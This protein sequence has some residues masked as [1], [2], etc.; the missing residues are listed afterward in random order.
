VKGVA[1]ALLAFEAITV[2]LAGLVA[3]T[4]TDVSST[5]AWSVC[6]GLFALCLAG[7]ATM[8][9][10]RTGWVLGS[11]AQVLAIATGFLVPAM[12]FLGAV[13]AA[14]WVLAYVLG[15]RMDAVTR[16]RAGSAGAGQG[17][18]QGAG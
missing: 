13:F 11:L 4:S 9:R 14:L 1:A 3:V 17:A 10:G 16:A 5:L 18:G 6:G 2:L 8:R 7:A 15:Q 12:F